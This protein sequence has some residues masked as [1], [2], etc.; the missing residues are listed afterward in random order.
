[1]RNSQKFLILILGLSILI[2]LGAAL[3]LGDQVVEL[4][5][6]ADQISYHS[7]A[8]RVLAGYGFSF[9]Q[10][11][12]PVTAAGA[13]TAHWSFLYT[14]FLTGVYAIFGPHPIAAR[15]IQAILVG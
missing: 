2:R 14:L 1:M 5:G 8:L 12:W 7:L 10:G 4:P 15:I 13:P 6:T 9:G 11:W 3:V